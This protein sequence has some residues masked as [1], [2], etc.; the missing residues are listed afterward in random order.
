MLVD[1]TRVDGTQLD[2]TD[3]NPTTFI[4]YKKELWM[5]V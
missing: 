5:I 1:Q 3:I 2:E 4:L